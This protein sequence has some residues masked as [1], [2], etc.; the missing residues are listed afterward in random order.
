MA[1]DAVPQAQ[2]LPQ[3]RFLDRA[4]QRHVRAIPGFRWSS[5]HLDGGGCDE[6]WET[7]LGSG[8][9]SRVAGVA[10]PT[11]RGAAGEP[12]AVLGGDRGGSVERGRGDRGRRVAP[13]GGP[14]VPGGGR[15]ATDD[16]CAISEA[17]IGAVSGV[18]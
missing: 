10:W 11:R 8:A 15:H 1:R 17:A 5:Q 2:E 6:G 13:G 18:R 12:A 7:A 3:E 14:L 4:E 16:P 9:P